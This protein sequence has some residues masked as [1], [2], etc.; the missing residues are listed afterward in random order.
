MLKYFKTSTL[1]AVVS[2]LAA[3]VGLQQSDL[4]AFYVALIGGALFYMLHVIEVKLNRLLNEQG[5]R[6]EQD[7]IDRPGT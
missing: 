1:V 5:L 6:V 4:A 7:E 3:I 2:F